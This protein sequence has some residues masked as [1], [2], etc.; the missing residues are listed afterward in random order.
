MSERKS[1]RDQNRRPSEHRPGRAAGFDFICLILLLA[2]VAAVA[3]VRLI[4]KYISVS[5]DNIRISDDKMEADL[6]RLSGE[7]YDSILISMHST[8]PFS[9]EDFV[10]FRGLDTVVA[11]HTLLN[12][13]ELS[14][15]FDCILR[16]GNTLSNVY[17]CLDPELLWINASEKTENWE[18]SLTSGLYSYIRS[19]PGISF[20]ILL[21]YPHIS[22]WLNFNQ[23]DL[24]ILLSVYLTLI[25]ELSSYPNTKTFFPGVE[26]W[27]IINPGNYDISSFDANE[28]VTNK[29][30][31]Y[32]FC[33]CV[34]QV[35]PE[36][37]SLFLDSLLSVV[38]RERNTPTHYPDLSDLY[39]VFLG[40]SILGN[41][42]GSISI[43]GYV[44]CLS[45]AFFCNFAVGGATAA[46]R[47]EN[48]SDFPN[49]IDRILTEHT[50]EQDGR[51]VFMSGEADA[52]DLSGKKLCFVIN[53][54]FNDYFNGTPVEDPENPGNITSYKGSL[55]TGISR[56][57]AVFPDACY[58]IMSP[59]HTARFGDDAKT[60]SEAGD[61]FPA[62]IEAAQELAAEMNLYFL[63][64]YN[65]FVVTE[66]NLDVYL[67]D[68]C[69]PNER[70]RLAI[71][72][73]LMNF[74]EENVK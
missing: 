8:E 59:T 62:Y 43:P 2:T 56:L 64:N 18:R 74:I 60:G 5:G 35:T 9:E 69:H 73:S 65:D 23:K 58:I 41:Y 27:L 6:E 29:L 68:G 33:D 13:E 50:S 40:D 20:E 55:R 11:S 52:E 63:D 26:E 48:G 30:F 54:G 67:S 28:I 61:I 19:N 37:E 3:A 12:T 71:A 39:I 57:Q 7:T 44:S 4:P 72:V 10:S 49:I 15:Y 45:D 51:S 53:Y 70:G 47:S 66:E 31:L 22:Y 42:A 32:T 34:Y 14:A 38:E 21:P 17:L 46:F 24:D 16:S 25:N 36:N 1:Y